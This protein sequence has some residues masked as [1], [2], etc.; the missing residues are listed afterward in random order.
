M[1]WNDGF[2][3]DLK[4]FEYTNIVMVGFYCGEGK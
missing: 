2:D 4:W 1:A 3:N